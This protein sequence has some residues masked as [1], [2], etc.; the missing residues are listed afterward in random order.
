MKSIDMNDFE[1]K[2]CVAFCFDFGDGSPP[3]SQKSPF[4]KHEYKQIGHYPVSV[5]VTDKNRLNAKAHCN[6]KYVRS[7]NSFVGCLNECV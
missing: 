3:I 5:L 7:L 1:N 4:I 6:Q 2:P